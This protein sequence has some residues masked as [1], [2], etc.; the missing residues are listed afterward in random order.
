MVRHLAKKYDSIL[1]IAYC[2]K[3]PAFGEP[4]TVACCSEIKGLKLKKLK[5][6]SQSVMSWT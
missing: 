2:K 6:A 4:D 1:S 5:E 3:D